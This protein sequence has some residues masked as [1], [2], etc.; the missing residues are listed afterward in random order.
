MLDISNLAM[1]FA[2]TTVID[3]VD[4]QVAAGAFVAVLGPS[5]CG[6]T[7]LLRLAAGALRPTAG[8]VT[9]DFARAAFV[10]QDSRLAPWMTAL[11]NAGFGLK[12]LGLAKAMRDD[13]ARRILLRLGF[14]VSDLGKRPH[15]LS[16]GMRQRV[17]LARALAVAPDLL[18]LDEPFSALDVGLRRD[19]QRMIRSEVDQ[20]GI[21]ALLVTHD[22]A[23]AVRLADRIIVLSPRPASI[24]AA[25]ANRPC[26][27]EAVIFETAAR[28][29]RTPGVTEALLR[30]ASSLPAPARE[31]AARIVSIARW[32]KPQGR[33]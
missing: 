7:T 15:A 29:L 2:G 24:V 19:M 30:P 8:R 18:L 10:F 26:D 31:S 4:L 16:G 11:D 20:A 13:Q 6:K 22:I 5:G 32:R 17:G 28:L 12:A 14:D 9:N 21:A 3:A 27:D 1:R 23:E 25:L 33:S